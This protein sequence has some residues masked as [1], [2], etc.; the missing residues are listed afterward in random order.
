[1][2]TATQFVLKDSPGT[3]RA[4][5]LTLPIH[6][7]P[8]RFRILDCGRR[9]GKSWVATAEGYAM[10]ARVWLKRRRAAQGLVVAPTYELVE[11]DWKIAQ[12]MLGEAIT[13]V[14][15]SRKLI[16]MGPLGTMEY[17]STDSQGGAGR[18]GGYDWAILDEA[19]RIPRSAWEDDIRPAL[20]DRQGRG[21]FISTPFGRNWFYE[22]F[23]KG[24]EASQALYKSWR[25][26]TIEGWRARATLFPELRAGYDAEWELIQRETSFR[27]FA[28]EYCAEFLEH[29][30]ALWSLSKILRGALRP[31][32]PTRRY[33]AGIDVAHV[34]DWMATAVLECESKQLVGLHRSRYRDWMIQKAEALALLRAYPNL[35]VLIDSTGMGDPIAQDL[36]AAGLTIED[37]VFTPKRKGELVENLSVA[38]DHG[39]LAVPDQD[40]T[41]W[42]LDELRAYREIKQPS[43]AIRYSAP[44]GQHDDG[45]TALMLAAWGL[46]QEL[47]RPTIDLNQPAKHVWDNPVSYL[48][49]RHRCA[50]WLKAYPTRPLPIHPD[51]LEWQANR[52]WQKVAA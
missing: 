7:H 17:R 50:K 39:Y 27:T 41:Q 28:Q 49:Y 20:A 4:S 9:F 31:P 29:E 47:Q 52:V 1:M 6:V 23:R 14:S 38:I 46:R 51:A 37:V 45:V 33:V 44:E 22:L 18:G 34:N 11:K 36:R 43:G 40:E 2:P 3:Y 21:V 24:Q 42:L 10:S 16:T 35:S 48:A 15:E 8:A 13:E 5:E 25:F 32:L 12:E 19:S 26:S 30:G